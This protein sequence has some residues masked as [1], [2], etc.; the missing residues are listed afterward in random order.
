MDNFKSFPS[1]F[2]AIYSVTCG[3][4]LGHQCDGGTAKVHMSRDIQPDRGSK[5]LGFKMIK[6]YRD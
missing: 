3:T 1:G 2:F 4:S 5:S 6:N